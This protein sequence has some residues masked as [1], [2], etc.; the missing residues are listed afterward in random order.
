M[1]VLS[2]IRMG[3]F[4]ILLAVAALSNRPVL[5]VDGCGSQ[6]P[7]ESCSTP[8]GRCTSGGGEYSCGVWEECADV[9]LCLET[10][11]WICDCAPC[12]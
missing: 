12:P 4:L 3:T 1:T 5:A 6:G 11:E 8:A 9:G 7:C 10:G 2:R